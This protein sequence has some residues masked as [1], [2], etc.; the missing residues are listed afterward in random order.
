MAAFKGKLRILIRPL[1]ATTP[2]VLARQ[3]L[4]PFPN[5][6]QSR[7]HILGVAAEM[8]MH[9]F[10]RRV[11]LPLSFLR[12]CAQKVHT[13][14]T[15]PMPLSVHVPCDLYGRRGELAKP[16]QFGLA[17][18]TLNVPVIVCG[19]GGVWVCGCVAMPE[20]AN[21]HFVA[22]TPLLMD[23]RAVKV[24]RGRGRRVCCVRQ[25]HVKCV[26]VGVV[27]LCIEGMHDLPL[28]TRLLAVLDKSAPVPSRRGST[29][30]GR[31]RAL[32]VLAVGGSGGGGGGSKVQPCR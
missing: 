16:P 12:G 25:G 30:S 27:Y 15:L 7:P 28:R 26:D 6:G 8:Y 11:P 31:G 14:C 18:S 2:R 19:G 22:I 23:V 13:C 5:G 10:S 9:P 32:V 20:Q 1:K 17:Q 21:A 29:T 24:D 3:K 4:G